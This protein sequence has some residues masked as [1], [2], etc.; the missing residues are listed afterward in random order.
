MHVRQDTM[1]LHTADL[2]QGDHNSSI[3]GSPCGIAMLRTL[4]RAFGLPGEH[5]LLCF[6]SVG[7]APRG[8]VETQF[9]LRKAAVI[10][11]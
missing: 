4:K 6:W 2:L 1:F 8:L 5:Q 11:G 9:S 3:P 10:D 7:H